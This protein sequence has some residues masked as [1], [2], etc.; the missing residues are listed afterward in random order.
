[1]GDVGTHPPLVAGGRRE[2]RARP[3]DPPHAGRGPVD[4]HVRPPIPVEIARWWIGR[5]Q[6]EH[7]AYAKIPPVYGGPVETPVG[8]LDER[9][10][11]VRA[12]ERSADKEVD[13]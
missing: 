2:E 7:H 5:P 1:H 13:D 11:G 4:G 6:P 3:Q 10:G 9:G 8:G 12:V